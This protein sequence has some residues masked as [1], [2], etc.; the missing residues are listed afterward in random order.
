MNRIAF[1]AA[2]IA[3]LGAAAGPA[4][5]QPTFNG[6]A[7]RGMDTANVMSRSY[8]S[9][10]WD[11]TSVSL[12]AGRFGYAR[13]DGVTVLEERDTAT[14]FR[15]ATPYRGT[16]DHEQDNADANIGFQF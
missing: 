1:F 2:T 6:T 9:A 11:G 4:N 3:V 16:S 8:P 14:D 7:D 15:R 12:G 5:A 10:Q 13:P